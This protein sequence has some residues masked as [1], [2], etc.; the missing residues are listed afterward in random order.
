MDGRVCAYAGSHDGRY[1]IELVGVGTFEF[2]AFEPA[3]TVEAAPS[4]T[5]SQVEKGYL[6]SILPFILQLRGCEVLHA[7]AVRG[8]RGVVGFCAPSET[9][10]TTLAYGLH[11]RGYP[12]WTDDVLAFEQNGDGITA[13]PVPFRLFL[14]ASAEEYFAAGGLYSAWEKTPQP[15]AALCMVKRLPA[16]SGGAHVIRRLPVGEAFALALAHGYAF[17]LE[18]AARK[19]LMLEGYLALVAATP[20]Y[21]IA[22]APGFDRFPAL[23]DLVE[24]TILAPPD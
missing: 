1:W 19:R 3:V 18:D 21:E 15:L 10:K 5:Q 9:G 16:A 22:L 6:N 23:L 14:R 17:S 20:V 13:L 7:S 24:R 8:P 4:A 11:Q 12:A 2:E